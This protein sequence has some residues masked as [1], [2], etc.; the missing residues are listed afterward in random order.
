MYGDFVPVIKCAW[1]VV[2]QEIEGVFDK[3]GHLILVP[4]A[5]RGRDDV[6]RGIIIFV[7]EWTECTA[8]EAE[9]AVQKDWIATRWIKGDA[10]LG[11]ALGIQIH[12]MCWMS[13]GQLVRWTIGHSECAEW[14]LSSCRRKNMSL[15]TGEWS[16]RMPLKT[17]NS[18]P[19][20]IR[21][22]LPFSNQNSLSL[23]L[24]FGTSSGIPTSTVLVSM[25]VLSGP[26][27]LY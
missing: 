17:W 10:Y 4:K 20:V 9:W 1:E 27:L 16:T 5:D 21:M 3:C 11:W 14:V 2:C 8:Y 18:T 15:K 12:R 22:I 7:L 13:I 25:I 23:S 6:K 24:I 19:P 26:A